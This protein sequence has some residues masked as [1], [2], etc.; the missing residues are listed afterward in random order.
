MRARFLIVPL[1]ALA[2]ACSTPDPPKITPIS[3]KVTAVGPKGIDL[4]VTLD[5]E[6]TN[7]IDL[8]ARSLTAKITLDSAYDAGTVTSSQRIDLPAH[9]KTRLDV[10][11]STKWHDITELGLLAA[12]DK[13]IPY[14]VDGTVELGTDSFRVD[15]PFHTSGTI[16]RSMML[17]A[18][19]G[20]LPKIPGVIP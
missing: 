7:A 19:L 4:S 2:A 15:V 8:T 9:K 14:K 6:N 11:V 3:A 17:K 12:G 1:L 5:A 13:D 18:A 16:S 10:P 20:A